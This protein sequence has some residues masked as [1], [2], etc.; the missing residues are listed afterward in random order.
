MVTG[1]GKRWTPPC[2]KSSLKQV[3]L[4]QSGYF[5][6][7]SPLLP[8]LVLFPHVTWVRHL[9]PPYN[10][11]QRPLWPPLLQ[12]PGVLR[13]WSLWAALCAK[14]RLCLF[15]S[16]PCWMVPSLVPK[17]GHSLIRFLIN[18]QHTKQDC[19]PNGPPNDWP[20]KRAHGKTIEAK[21]STGHSTPQGDWEPPE[22]PLEAHDNGMGASRSTEEHNSEDNTNHSGDESTKDE[23][24]RT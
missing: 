22:T 20:G 16:F 23:S 14:L 1:W 3:Q 11:E 15:P 12:N 9:L 19:S 13:P 21:V 24:R 5:P 7:A 10:E 6:G 17:V 4:T 8:I 18:P 2:G